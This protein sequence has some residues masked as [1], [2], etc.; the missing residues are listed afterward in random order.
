MLARRAG[1]TASVVE[2]W[3]TPTSVG[4]A[5][6][7]SRAS[8]ATRSRCGARLR[9]RPGRRPRDHARRR[10]ARVAART[11]GTSLRPVR[12]R[13]ASASGTTSSQGSRA[14]T[15]GRPS[16]RP[17]PAATI[18]PDALDAVLVAF[19]DFADL[20]SPWIRGHSRRVA[21][22]AEEAGRHAGLDNAARDGLRRAGLVHDLGRVAV[23]NGIWDKAGALDDLGMGAR[24]A[25]PSLH[26]ADPRAVRRACV[27]RPAGLVTPRASSTGPGITGRWAPSRSRARTGSWPRRTSTRRSRPRAAPR[28]ARAGRRRSCARGRLG[29]RCPC[30]RLRA[31][32]GRPAGGAPL[33]QPGRPAS[34]TARW[35]CCA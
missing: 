13:R 26:R 8:P 27:P 24:A 14:R 17:E 30:G 9:G 23:E 15:S 6:G 5:K 35:R 10:P 16:W 4:T 25:P 11:V 28:C 32:S 12:R 34:P 18:E 29:S 1:L 21:S 31:R 20:K 7:A 3:P 2:A 19:A 22:L 33:P